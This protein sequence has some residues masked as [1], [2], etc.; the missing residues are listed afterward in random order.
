[1]EDIAYRRPQCDMGWPASI[2]SFLFSARFKIA[3]GVFMGEPT[4]IWNTIHVFLSASPRRAYTHHAFQIDLSFSV[5]REGK[6]SEEEKSI[7]DSPVSFLNRDLRFHFHMHS[8]VVRWCFSSMI[9][10]IIFTH[11]SWFCL[12]LYLLILNHDIV[13]ESRTFWTFYLTGLS[14]FR[15]I[16]VLS[17]N[18]QQINK[19]YNKLQKQNGKHESQ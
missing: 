12:S 14:I 15:H 19:L 13:I 17:K 10:F 16:S 3:G 2:S 9:C 8:I 6:N 4:S 7:R 1:M 11:F 18:H 5:G